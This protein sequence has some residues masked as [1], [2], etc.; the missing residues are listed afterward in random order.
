MSL[1]V[2]W[3]LFWIGCVVALS[4]LAY[5]KN[6]RS[7][8]Q[9]KWQWRLVKSAIDTALVAVTFVFTPALLLMY[10][11]IWLSWPTKNRVAQASIGFGAVLLL[12]HLSSVVFEIVAVLGIFA[13][14]LV[15]GQVVA[16]MKHR[17]AARK[18]AVA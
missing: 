12:T 3:R 8:P 14:D 2:R 4:S 15:T 6:S 1:V 17:Q 5:W 18:E 16:R 10:I 13:I 9:M 7:Y 11:V